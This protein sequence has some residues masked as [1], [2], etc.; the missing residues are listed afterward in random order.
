MRLVVLVVIAACGVDV[1]SDY[2]APTAPAVIDGRAHVRSTPGAHVDLQTPEVIIG[3]GEER[4]WCWYIDNPLGELAISGVTAFQ[5]T[6]G[7]HMSLMIPDVEK[8]SGTLEDCTSGSANQD[9]R[10]FVQATEPLPDGVA[11]QVPASMR[12]VVQFHYVNATDNPRLLQ[13]VLRFNL[14]TPDASTKWA[15]TMVA[16]DVTFALPPGESTAHY[17]CALDSD[18]DLV[19][20]VGHMHETGSKYQ[21]ALGP[22][23]DQLTTMQVVD[24]WLPQYRDAAPTLFY[25]DQPLHLPAGTVFETTCTWDNPTAQTLVYPSEMCFTFTYVLNSQTPAACNGI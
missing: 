8:P 6:G 15:T 18:R 17:A 25:Y 21:I 7:H 4:Q 9:M 14:V 19:V 5:G 23:V 16:S 12:L 13:D 10:W 22:S 20:M 3:A 11:L 24:P 2:V 1:P